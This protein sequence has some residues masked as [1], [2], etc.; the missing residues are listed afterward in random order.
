MTATEIT[1]SYRDLADF[2]RRA[3]EFNL[4]SPVAVI[5][6]ADEIIAAEDAPPLWAI[7]LSLAPADADGIIAR[8]RQVPGVPNDGVPIHLFLALVD[9]E[10]LRGRLTINKVGRIGWQLHNENAIPTSAE[11]ADWGLV[12]DSLLTYLD[13][14]F[15][16]KIQVE[17]SI[18]ELLAPYGQYEHLLPAWA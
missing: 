6:W 13:E 10:W 15:C 4:I 17:T 16:T 1:P 11:Q 2:A 12:V 18:D 9:R 14:G 5:A 7:E 8:L 3:I